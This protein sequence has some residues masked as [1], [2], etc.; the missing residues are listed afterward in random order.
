M[1]G[2]TVVWG[3]AGVNTFWAVSC[4]T[5]SIMATVEV[6]AATVFG[7]PNPKM[8]ELEYEK[9]SGSGIFSKGFADLFVKNCKA[10]S[11]SFISNSI[12]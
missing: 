5:G 3:L 9:F 11:V 12:L 10:F 7:S 1:I 2:G 6:S 8:P 4:E